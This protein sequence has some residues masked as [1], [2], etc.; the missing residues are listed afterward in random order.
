MQLKSQLLQS[1]KSTIPKAVKIDSTINEQI[2]DGN[3]L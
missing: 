2:I 3:S 1:L